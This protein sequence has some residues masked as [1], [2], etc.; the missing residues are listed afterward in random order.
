MK[1][2]ILAALTAAALLPALTACRAPQKAE[3]RPDYEGSKSSSERHHDSLDK[4]ASGY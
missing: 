2:L 4:E 3:P 1:N